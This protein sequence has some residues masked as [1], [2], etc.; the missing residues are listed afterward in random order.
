MTR[1][2]S[3]DLRSRVLAASRD[4]MRRDL[5]RPGLGS[6]FNTHSLDRQRTTWTDDA[7]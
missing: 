6:A 1:A 5:R 3:N 4:G 7:S 2:F